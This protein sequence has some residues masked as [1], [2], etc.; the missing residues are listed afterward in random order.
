MK[1]KIATWNISCGIPAKW[2]LADGIK[3]E[4]DFS[5]IDARLG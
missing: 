2:N 5:S 4:K 3:K 1:L